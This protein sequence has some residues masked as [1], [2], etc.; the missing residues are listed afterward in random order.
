MTAIASKIGARYRTADAT[1]IEI[2]LDE[3]TRASIIAAACVA[4]FNAGG[5]A[6]DL[7]E[8]RRRAS[9]WDLPELLHRAAEVGVK[10]R[11]GNQPWALPQV[12]FKDMVLGDALL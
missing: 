5:R 12:M 6:W 8:W 3:A 1:P 4:M 11:R 9:D 7:G 2:N 10:Y